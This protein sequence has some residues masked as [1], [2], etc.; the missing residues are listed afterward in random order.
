MRLSVAADVSAKAG[1]AKL[2]QDVLST[3]WG[4]DEVRPVERQ[5]FCFVLFFI[6][7]Q[8]NTAT[9]RIKSKLGELRF[10]PIRLTFTGIRAFPDPNSARSV[11][12]GVD[13]E[14][15]SRLAKL[16]GKVASRMKEIGLEPDRP[17]IPHLTIF[18]TKGGPLEM[19][20]SFAKYRG[21]DFGSDLI[22]RIRLKKSNP[23]GSGSVYSDI[24]TVNS[25]RRPA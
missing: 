11:W 21:R 13:K 12:V 24:F 23:A 15:A 5:N 4:P 7:E 10:D 19:G 16:A 14:G 6:G 3:I 20:R 2:Q 18:H 8:D 17:F 1:I 22:D 9:G 25:Q